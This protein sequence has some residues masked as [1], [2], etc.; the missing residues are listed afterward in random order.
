M[1]VGSEVDWTNES[2]EYYSLACGDMKGF[3]VDDTGWLHSARFELN[4]PLDG[5]TSLD[6]AL[7]SVASAFD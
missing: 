1:W 3:M 2:L 7:A 6:L 5:V 4:W